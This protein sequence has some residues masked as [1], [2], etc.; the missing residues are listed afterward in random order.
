MESNNNEVF[1]NP[2]TDFGFK[3]LFGTPPNKDILISFLNAL[4][5]G[6]RKTIVDLYYLNT[7]V[8]GPYYGD[9]NSVFD[10]YCLSE[11]GTH[12][13]VEMQRSDQSYFKDRTVYYASASIVQQAPKGEWNYNL[14]DVCVVG[15]LN[16]VFPNREY[17]DDSYVHKVKLKD[18]DDN[19]EVYDKLTFYYVE[20]PKFK[21]KEN[22]LVTMQD[23]WL[24]VLKNICYLLSQPKELQEKVFTKFFEEARIG[25]F[26]KEERFAYM[27]S[28]KHYWDNHNTIS[29]SYEKGQKAGMEAGMKEGRVQGLA[30]GKALG[31][32]EGKEL[33]LAEGRELGLAEGKELG[34]AEGKE[35]GLAE[36]LANAKRELAQ[37]MLSMGIS[38]EVVSELTGCSL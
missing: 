30:E 26:T 17:A 5:D 24:F 11:D 35:L 15:I 10:V 3:K 14:T 32:A 22:E 19:H 31:L 25:M 34:L 9:R 13:I 29:Y 6:D 37:K 7:E 33:G 21:K 18:T 2:Y 36:G 1:M 38:Q 8:L 28:Q 20:M 16:F 23:K 4:F 27:V 12:F